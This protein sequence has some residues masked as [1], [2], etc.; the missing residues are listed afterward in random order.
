MNFVVNSPSSRSKRFPFHY[1]SFHHAGL[2]PKERRLV[3]DNFRSHRKGYGRKDAINVIYNELKSGK[4][5]ILEADIKGF[6]ENIKHDAILSKIDIFQGF[7]RRLLKVY[8]IEKGKKYK[9]KKGIPQGNPL[10]PILANIA[11]HGMQ[12]IFNHQ[13][14]NRKLNNQDYKIRLIRYADDFVVIAPT[15][16]IIQKSILPKLNKFLKERGLSLNAEKTRIVSK[17]VGFEF[18]GFAIKKEEYISIKEKKN[19]I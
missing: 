4:K 14:T 11:L 1:S 12:E 5:V 9:R 19:K 8:I 7:I 13:S 6:F 17:E 18:L 10:S 16:K 2:L 3:E 15:I